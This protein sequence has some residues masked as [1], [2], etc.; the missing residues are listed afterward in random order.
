MTARPL[1]SLGDLAWDVLAKPDTPLQPGG[2]TTGRL[3]LAGG[4][5]AANLAVWAARV[6][7]AAA[8][9]GKIGRDRFGQLAVMDL[10]AEGVTAHVIESAEHPTGVILSLIDQGGQRSMLSGQGADWFLLPEEVPADEV[11][12]AGHLHVTAWSLFSDPP[13]AAALRAVEIAHAA[14]VPVSLDPGSFQMIQQFGRNDFLRLIEQIPFSLLLPNVDEARILSGEGEP[15][16]ML[17]W[18]ARRFPGADV[19][20]KLDAQGVLLGLRGRDA[21]HVPATSD[22]AVDA[23]G[24]GDAFGGAYL[25]HLLRF[26]DPVRAAACAVDASGWVIRH[27][28]ARAPIDEDLTAR[29]ER[30][31]VTAQRSGGAA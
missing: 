17:A 11:R 9:A 16:A 13:R 5:S 28:G 1:L 6:G 24:A 19:A 21:V 14:G 22:R 7:Q 8:F 3:E 27:F 15:H 31:G 30:H 18:F 23:T 26:G 4:G 10:R 2:D 12:T 25:G 20:L 29:L